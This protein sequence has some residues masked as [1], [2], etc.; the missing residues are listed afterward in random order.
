M[1][2]VSTAYSFPHNESV[3]KSEARTRSRRE[4]PDE[5]KARRGKQNQQRQELFEGSLEIDTFEHT[6]PES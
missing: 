1:W 2:P 3:S 4:P 6:E 5:R